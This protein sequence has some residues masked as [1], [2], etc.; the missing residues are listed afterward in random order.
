MKY[1]EQR[2]EEL[3]K[4]LALLKAKFK[5]Q[6]TKTTG[7]VNTHPI[8]VQNKD[9]SCYL[10]NYPP[11]PGWR[12]KEINDYMFNSSVNL[13]SEPDLETSFASPWDSSEIIKNPLD[14]IT[15]NLSSAVSDS[16]F[17]N[18]AYVDS[19]DLP[20]YY[21]PYPDV[22]SSW[23]E[24]FD[25]VITEN[26]TNEFGFKMNYVEPNT[27]SNFDKMDKGFLEYLN[28]TEKKIEKL[29]GKI[30][31]KFKFLN[32]QWEM[33]GYGYVVNT[34]NNKKIIVTNHGKPI[35]VDKS[36]IETKISEYK[37]V[38]QETQRALFLIK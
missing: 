7:F 13:M 37:E 14:T 28:S 6:E 5:L 20:E 32:H 16:I 11:S 31:S 27:D 23:D 4:E 29:Y 19:S 10:N 3:E 21:P 15:V 9:A 26:I 18:P 30:I 17:P 24:S 1:L 33:D 22:T 8:R 25:D 36:Y 35:A 38:I 34:G 2:V 12:N